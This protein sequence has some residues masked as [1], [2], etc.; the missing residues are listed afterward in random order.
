[1]P[2]NGFDKE[3][4]ANKCDAFMDQVFDAGSGPGGWLVVW[5]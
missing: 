2:D 1:M 3:L 4:Y 5:I